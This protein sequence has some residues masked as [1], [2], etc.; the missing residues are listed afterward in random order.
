MRKCSRSKADVDR[1]Y[2]SNTDVGSSRPAEPA[3]YFTGSSD[4][5]FGDLNTT[6][7]MDWNLPFEVWNGSDIDFG[8]LFDGDAT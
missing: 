5:V 2:N 8:A 6:S 7:G 4:N 1:V 3:N